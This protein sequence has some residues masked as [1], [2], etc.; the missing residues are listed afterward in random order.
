LAIV[1]AD[2]LHIER[3]NIAMAKK[4]TTK[5]PTQDKSISSTDELTKTKQGG[6]E[7]TEAELRRASG[8]FALKGNLKY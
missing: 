4:P 7:L 2:D 1:V 6:I 5:T 8:G 3:G